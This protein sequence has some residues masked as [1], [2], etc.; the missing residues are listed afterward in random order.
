[1]AAPDFSSKTVDLLASRSGL[2][3]NNPNCYC[4]TIGPSENN[5]LVKTKIGEAAHICAAR[6]GEARYDENMDNNQRADI[7][8]GLWLC[9]SCHTMIDKDGGRDFPKDLYQLLLTSPH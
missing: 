7:S 8:N 3:C 6:K 5:P 1:M 9:A 4:L 2:I